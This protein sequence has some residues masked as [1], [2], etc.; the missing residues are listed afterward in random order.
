MDVLNFPL[1]LVWFAPVLLV[2][3][4][5]SLALKLQ[6]RWGF[7]GAGI[8]AYIVYAVIGY[9]TLPENLGELPVHARWSSRLAQ[10]AAGLAMVAVAIRAARDPLIGREAMGLT[11]K[12][13]PGSVPMALA[14]VGVLALLGAI[15]G[16]VEITSAPTTAAWAYHLTLPGIE[17]EII[18]RGLLTGLFAAGLGGKRALT[19][20][21][22]PATLVF[23]LAHAFTPGANGG[24]DFS[25]MTFAVTLLAGAIM[26][27]M[28]IRTG[29]LLLP[30]VGHNLLGLAVI[31]A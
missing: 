21:S 3:L 24:V 25:P 12:Q 8:L 13:A 18:Y 15:L 6:V 11:L 27:D 17:E 28:R 31:Y 7:I 30:A 19:W 2:A 14:G 29:S 22:V 5:L 20:G 10:L 26:A 23:A 4:G 9:A 16:G 1:L